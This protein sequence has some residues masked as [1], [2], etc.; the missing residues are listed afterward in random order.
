MADDFLTVAKALRPLTKTV[1]PSQVT[2]GRVIIHE[3]Q[4]VKSLK[5][6]ER[7]VVS[8]L[9]FAHVAD[10]TGFE[11]V[12]TP[13]DVGVIAYLQASNE[14]I[15]DAIDCLVENIKKGGY[16][17]G[18]WHARENLQ[19]GFGGPQDPAVLP[20][21]SELAEFLAEL[22]VEVEVLEN[23]DGQIQTKE[24]LKPS[25]TLVLKARI[26]A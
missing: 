20:S 17:I 4:Q 15:F 14:D 10:A 23:R 21:A 1:T 11:S 16:L 18:V 25:V 13:V 22:P 19:G 9:Y 5:F 24:G 6:A 3:F 8:D 2:P 26:T 7:R 12:L